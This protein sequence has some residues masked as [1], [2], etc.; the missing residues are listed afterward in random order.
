MYMWIK[1]YGLP[2][3]TARDS[4]GKFSSNWAAGRCADAL[5]RIALKLKGSHA[6]MKAKRIHTS[7]QAYARL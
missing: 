2:E 6:S 1:H 7:K 3:Q 5:I 4:G